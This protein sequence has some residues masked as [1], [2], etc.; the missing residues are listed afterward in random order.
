MIE[1]MT[2]ECGI[3]SGRTLGQK[4]DISIGNMSS[5][6]K[7]YRWKLLI[8]GMIV[9]SQES[10]IQVGTRTPEEQGNVM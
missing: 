5:Q 1:F 8:F 10:T 2:D 9:Y 3:K 4:H 7:E 6:K